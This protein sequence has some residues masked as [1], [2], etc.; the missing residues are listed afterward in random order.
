MVVEAEVGTPQRSRLIGNVD[1][2]DTT[3]TFLSND[4]GGKTQRNV[5]YQRSSRTKT[6]QMSVRHRNVRNYR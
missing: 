4:Y 5:W 3:K 1:L 2:G 6:Q